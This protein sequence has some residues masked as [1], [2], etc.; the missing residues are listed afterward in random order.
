[1]GEKVVSY[2][3]AIEARVVTRVMPRL[4]PL[5]VGLY[6]LN[7]LD[8]VNVAFAELQMSQR[9]GFTRADYGLAAGIFFV[10]YFIFE[11]PSNLIMQRVGARLW[12]ARIMISWGVISA[13]ML[14]VTGLWSFCGLRFLLGLAEA[15]F[16]PGVLLY[17]THWL[18]AK[19]QAKAVAWFLT[20]TALSGLIGAPLAG[21]LL[22]M[23]GAMGLGGWQWL[24]LLEGLPSVIMGV[25]IFFALVDR[26]QNARWLEKADREWLTQRLAQEQ[27]ERHSGGH[28]GLLAGL[29]SGKIWLLNVIYC[30]L[31]FG[32]QG[33]NYWMPKIIKQVTHA[34]DNL[35]VGLLTAIPYAAAMIAMVIVGAH[36]DR[37]RERRWH[38]TVCSAIGAI[39]L[40]A[41]AW[42]ESPL[43]AIAG[44]SIAAAGIW[45]T[46][47]PFWALP[48]EFLGGTAAAAGIALVNSIGNL[49]GGFLGPYVMGK[50]W[51]R[52]QSYTAGLLIDAGAL[53]L[54][55]G[56][57]LL[58]RRIRR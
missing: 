30:M 23:D 42:T 56:L 39:G 20:S 54:G 5:L 57:I 48:P 11:V 32:F 37:T 46:L 17:L 38:V 26:P 31:M 27:R 21:V 7:Y 13:S 41:C 40:L 36:S 53:A 1:M 58:V 50:L 12:M 9:F 16:A 43:V 24:F 2:A 45:A 35:I 49:G 6:I 22:K 47:G 3:E 4:I 29:F 28:T 51:D 52:T 10:G 19:E 18:P 44:L 15:G 25:V 8:R 33:I 55:A 14:F 34:Q